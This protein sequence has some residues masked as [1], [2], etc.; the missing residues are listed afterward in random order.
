MFELNG[1]SSDD[2]KSQYALYQIDNLLSPPFRTATLVE[3][4]TIEGQIGEACGEDCVKGAGVGGD[5]C[6]DGRHGA[7]CG[8]A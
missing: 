7:G 1:S 3:S 6:E 5:A 4:E 8:G 2:R